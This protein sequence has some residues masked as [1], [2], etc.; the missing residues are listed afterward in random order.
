MTALFAINC[1]VLTQAHRGKLGYLNHPFA[2]Y[3]I[4]SHISYYVSRRPPSKISRLALY[5]RELNFCWSILFVDP[6][7]ISQ[8]VGDCTSNC[9]SCLFRSASKRSWPKNEFLPMIGLYPTKCSRMCSHCSINLGVLSLFRDDSNDTW[10]I[11]IICD[12]M[13]ITWDS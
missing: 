13:S 12:N 8:I 7:F 9:C 6:Q 3:P 1:W 11:M 5:R 4:Y 2:N 10:I